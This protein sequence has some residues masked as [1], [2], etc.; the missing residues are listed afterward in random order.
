MYV[1]KFLKVQCECG[2]DSVVYGDAKSEVKC[3]NCKKVLLEPR[4]G[5]PK[6]NC[7]ILEIL[8]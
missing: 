2:S 8:G 7:K 1:S 4:G 3:F 5:R 6:V